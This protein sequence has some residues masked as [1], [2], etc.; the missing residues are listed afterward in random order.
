MRSLLA[1]KHKGFRAGSI[2][3]GLYAV[4]AIWPEMGRRA[5]QTEVKLR[6][7]EQR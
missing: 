3:V 4:G 7:K 1:R 2:W 6:A 5:L